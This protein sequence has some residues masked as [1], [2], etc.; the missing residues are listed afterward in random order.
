MNPKRLLPALLLGLGLTLTQLWLLDGGSGLTNAPITSADIHIAAPALLD[1]DLSKSVFPAG[2]I[3]AGGVLRYTIAYTNTGAAP[4]TNVIITD[5]IPPHTALLSVQDGGLYANGVIT[6][7]VGVVP[8][9]GSGA[10]HF[11]VQVDKPLAIGTPITNV[12]HLS[13]DQTGSLETN[14]TTNTVALMPDFGLSYKSATGVYPIKPGDLITY[15]VVYTNGGTLDALDVVITD[16]VP[17]HTTY[18]TGGVYA[19]GVVRFDLGGVNMGTGGSVSFSVRINED[20]PVGT[21]I[22]NTAT[23][24]SHQTLPV[25]TDPVTTTVIAPALTLRKAVT[26]TGG[27]RPNTTLTYTLTYT[28]DGNL[29]AT[30]VV[31]TEA[32]PVGLVYLSGGDSWDGETLSWTIGTLPIGASGQVT[33]TAWVTDGVGSVHNR[34][35][36]RSDQRGLQSSNV[37]TTP[38]LMPVLQVHKTVT[39]ARAM[40]PNELLTYTLCYTN[41]GALTAT[42]ALLLD[43]LPEGLDHI[44]GGI[45]VEST[46]FVSFPLGTVLAGESGSVNFTARVS[47]AQGTTVTNIAQIFY[48]QLY[49]ATYVSDVPLDV[50]GS[51]PFGPIGGANGL[52]YVAQS[53]VATAP[54]LRRAGIYIYGHTIPYPDVRVQLWGDAAGKPDPT[55]VLLTGDVITDLTGDGRRYFVHPRYPI[56]LTVGARYW[57]VIDGLVDTVTNGAAGTR[58]AAGNPYPDGGWVYSYNEGHDWLDGSGDLN[59]H[60]EY[61]SPPRSNAVTT[62]IINRAPYTPTNPSPPDGATGVPL[63]QVLSWQ[64]GDPDGDVV[65]YTLALD[66]GTPPS[67]VTTCITTMYDPGVLQPLTTYYWAITVTDGLSLTAGDVWTFTTAAPPTE[68]T[69]SGPTIGVIGVTYGFTATVGPVTATQPITYIWRA[70]GQS[71]VTH[72]DGLSDAVAFTW[73]TPGFE[74]ITVTVMN[75]GGMLTSTHTITL[76]DQPLLRLSPTSLFFSAVE[77]SAPPPPQSVTISNGGGGQL[78]WSA[79]KSASWLGISPL[80]GTAPSTLYV[81]VDIASLTIGTYTGTITI[82]GGSGTL[83]SPQN[84]WVEL[85]IKSGKVYLP[86]V[87]RYWPPIPEAPTLHTISNP[88]GDGAYTVSWSRADYATHYVLEEATNDAFTGG[89]EVYSG[90]GTSCAISGRGAARYYYRVKACNRDCSEWSN[91]EWVDVLWEA[92]PNNSLAQANGPLQSGV[93]YYGYPNDAW[94]YFNVYVSTIGRITVDLMNHTGEGVQ[95][96]LYD[97]DG[98]LLDR[99]WQPPYH[100]ESDVYWGWYSIRIYTE[101]GY[102]S[103][104]PYTLRAVFP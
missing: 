77:G 67:V 8:T 53:F 5:T 46:D 47:A 60:V 49:P 83:D 15:T 24:A 72:T 40:P 43:P 35:Y 88:D 71:P 34:A 98:V 33:F 18:V 27:A 52:D 56:S 50:S 61:V 41:V 1:F 44:A 20:T 51:G 64:G 9:A 86:V 59:V 62:A 76:T 36:L 69:I 99:A 84:V 29:D 82:D 10:V 25:T 31:I 6:W 16:Y 66:T 13:S 75:A 12:A 79:S 23:V 2:N 91:V 55:Q 22:T 90:S 26:P 58:Y 96:L 17:T 19:D 87:M 14:I 103:D 73:D 97:Q 65:T 45:Y 80:T 21:V 38:V 81:S 101:S 68:M 78:N 70:T 104:T 4:A 89:L 54:R 37:V 32:L 95:L 3:A 30:G 28:N 42:G 85:R 92:E 48:D 63:T 102:N 7:T 94:D 39:P 100:V 11:R 57:L 93:G 74:V